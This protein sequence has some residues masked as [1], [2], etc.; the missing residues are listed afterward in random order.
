MSGITEKLS[1]FATETK[2]VDLPEGVTYEMKRLLLDTIG[3]ALAGI[4][5]GKG[6]IAVNLAKRL[7][8]PR[9]STIIGNNE[10]VSCANAA[11]ANGQLANALDFDAVGA[12]GHDIAFVIPASV[13]MAESIQASGPDL[14]VAIALGLEVDRR[15]A[16]AS[17]ATYSAVPVRSDRGTTSWAP[18]FGY[19]A[20]TFG[21]SVAAGKIL[22]LSQEKMANAIAIAGYLCA[23]DVFRKWSDTTP[24][25]MTKQG[26]FGWGAQT[27]ITS[28]LLA[29]MGYTGD[30]HLFEGPYC[31]WRYTG[32]EEWN[33]ESIL[34]ALGT[35]WG[36][37]QVSYKFY[38]MGRCL[39]AAVDDFIQIVHEND[40]QPGD[41]EEITAK[42]HPLA[43]FRMIRENKLTTEDD[44]LFNLRYAIACAVHRINP[45]RWHDA[46]VRQDQSIWEFLRKVDIHITFDEREFGLARSVDPGASPAEVQVV[47][48]GRALSANSK[49]IRGSWRPE[50]F[51]MKDEELKQKFRD[52]ASRTLSVSKINK[53]VEVVS[54]LE[55]LENVVQLMELVA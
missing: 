48:K 19:S 7:G 55:D 46:E 27:G 13:A 30:T 24:I 34:E 42:V 44:Y 45:A 36:C 32:K 33:V 21:A 35:K 40:L 12:G 22:N 25:S 54:K 31:F 5:T 20:S 17:P 23:P 18:V 51:R 50:E 15:I 47:A 26:L 41:V 16:G 4:S 53:V 11:W 29:H 28:A 37:H 14:I 38:P 10:R 39:P 6:G 8:G 2:F 1:E 49:Y 3:C 43:Q 52:N 9:E